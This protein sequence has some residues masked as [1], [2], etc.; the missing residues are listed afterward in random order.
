MFLPVRH[1][2]PA[3]ARMVR[4]LILR[5]RPR[6]VLIEGPADFNDRLGELRLGHKLPI[7]IYSYVSWSDGGRQGAYYPF[8]LYSPEWQ[9]LQAAWAVSAEVRFIDLPY[10][11]VAREDRRT[12]RYGDGRLRAHDYVHRLCRT[13]EVDDFDAAWD[14]LFEHDARIAPEAVCGRSAEFGEHLRAFDEDQVA[15]YD[16]AREDF[17]AA[18]I[19]AARAEFG[20][21]QVAVVTGSYHTPALRDLVESGSSEAPEIVWPDDLTERGLAL[22][23]YSYERLDQLAGYEAGMPSPGFYHAAWQSAEGKPVHRP[24]LA[25]VARRVR[26]LRQPASTADLIAVEACAQSLAAL[27]GH[28]QVWR[29][30]LIDA[31]TGALVKDELHAAHPFLAEL[32]QV[33]RGD[34]RGKLAAGSPLPPLVLDVQRRLEAADLVPAR[35]AREVRLPLTEPEAME[36]SRLLHG[37]RVLGVPGFERLGGTDFGLREDLSELYELW[38]LAWAA[39]QDAALIESSRYGSALDEAVA[40]R[41]HELAQAIHGSAARGARL[42]L[43]AVLADVLTLAG[44]MRERLTELIHADSSLASVSSALHDLLYLYGRDDALGT[45][46][47]APIGE[48][49]ALAFERGRWLLEV[50]GA[51]GARADGADVQAVR[52]LRDAFEIGEQPLT[53]DRGEFATVLARVQADR[54]RPPGLRGACA[55]ALWTLRRADPEHIRRDLQ[56]FAEPEQLGDFLH[57]LFT[58]AREESSR[59]PQ[60]LRAIDSVVSAWDE[61][62]YLAALPSLRLAFMAFTPREKSYLAGRLFGPPEA[63]AE[64]APLSVS[65]AEAEAALRFEAGLLSLAAEYGIDL[66]LSQ[67]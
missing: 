44:P 8:C 67:P 29:R 13:L 59:D 1:H 11:L 52:S 19:R 22:T 65:V 18:H 10:A 42:L 57:G 16:V 39:E 62:S 23:P 32:H 61:P 7:A 27:R 60:L 53:L 21:D 40:A 64:P 45:R 36:R 41:L 66:T 30:D 6:A 25:A 34:A 58:L 33:L 54:Q 48:A 17:M 43:D 14:L 50:A 12:H 31:I 37:L 49:L 4:D 20:P 55:G 5:R 26:A 9:A 3:C 15:T 2:S 63:A 46:G 28:A 38:R 47:Q 24:L 51:S 35:A 56:L